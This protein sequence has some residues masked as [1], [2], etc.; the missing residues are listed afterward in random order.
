[1]SRK[2]KKEKPQIT[3]R[4]FVSWICARDYDLIPVHYAAIRKLTRDAVVYVWDKS[5]DE[6]PPRLPK[7]A[8]SIPS[9]FERAGNLNGKTC[10]ENM[11]NCYIRLSEMGVERIVKTDVD[12]ILTALDWVELGDAVGFHCCN[13]YHF[14]GCC[15][16][17]AASTIMGIY[18]YL[19][20][21]D[22]Q[23]R[24]GYTLPEDMTFTIL[25]AIT[26]SKV[27]ILE[28]G[29]FTCAGFSTPMRNKPEAVRAVR[30]VIH[31]GQW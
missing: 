20:K 19:K 29:E 13:G 28:N 25:A 15:Y 22:I 31:C 27:V 5:K 11:I 16:S 10:I 14:T 8:I 17:L 30:G 18:E 26:G 4:V 12:T 7:G 21:H 3:P 2:R 6:A 9:D 23:P 1:M 24:D